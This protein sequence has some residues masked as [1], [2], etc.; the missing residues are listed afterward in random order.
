MLT[1]S[2]DQ[3]MIELKDGAFKNVGPPTKTATVKLYDVTRVDAR[4]F[5]DERVK[6][7]F[8]DADGNLVEVAVFPADAERLTDR[9]RE[10][11]ETSPIFD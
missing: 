8:E 4:E 2:I 9:L 6:L 10:L 5:G 3:F 11:A 1:M 7:E